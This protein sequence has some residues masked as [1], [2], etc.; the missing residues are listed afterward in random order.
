MTDTG[1]VPWHAVYPAPKTSVP[2]VSREEV[3]AWSQERRAGRDF[4]LVDVRRTDFEVRSTS[5]SCPLRFV[6]LSVTYPDDDV[7]F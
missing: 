1:E 4:V 2:T 3:L 5:F 6:H 7:C